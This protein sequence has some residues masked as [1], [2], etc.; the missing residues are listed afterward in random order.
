MR[1]SLIRPQRRRQSVW[2]RAQNASSQS[3]E[4]AIEKIQIS[5]FVAVPREMPSYPLLRQPL[6]NYL[7][8]LCQPPRRRARSR[9]GSMFWRGREGNFP[10][11]SC[12][13]PRSPGSEARDS[14]GECHPIHCGVTGVAHS[15]RAIE[16][17]PRRPRSRAPR[18]EHKR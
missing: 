3:Q 18:F 6:P 13:E 10:T 4:V 17:I 11:G 8:A 5:Q 14:V 12:R 1:R 2:I 7:Q 16:P 15:K 9:S